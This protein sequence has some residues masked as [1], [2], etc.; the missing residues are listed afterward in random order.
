M[1]KHLDFLRILTLQRKF[2]FWQEFL[3]GDASPELEY[4]PEDLYTRGL[5]EINK[6]SCCGKH[7]SLPVGAD[8]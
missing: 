6:S 2:K 7:G 8:L 3:S 4:I 5:G 1:E